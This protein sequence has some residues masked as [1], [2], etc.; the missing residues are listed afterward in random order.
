[1]YLKTMGIYTKKVRQVKGLNPRALG[2][3]WQCY[4]RFEIEV[5]VNVIRWGQAAGAECAQAFVHKHFDHLLPLLRGAHVV[6]G[7]AGSVGNVREA[8]AAVRPRGVVLVSRG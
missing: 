4:A 1:M 2:Q 8:P 3:V 6:I 7:T 5:S